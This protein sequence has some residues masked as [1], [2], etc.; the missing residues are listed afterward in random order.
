LRHAGKMPAHPSQ[1]GVPR[2]PETCAR[3][4]AGN[5]VG[6]SAP[7]RFLRRPSRMRSVEA[8]VQP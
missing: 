2:E 6:V 1:P 4:E 7:L 5:A 8:T 3:A